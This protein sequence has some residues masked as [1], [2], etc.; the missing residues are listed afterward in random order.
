MTLKLLEILRLSLVVGLVLALIE[1]AA[2][3]GPPELQ[4]PAPVIYLADNL[5]ET[6]N[7]GW[8]IDTVGRGL[9]DRLHAHSCKAF[10]G[11]VQFKYSKASRQIMSATFPGK[12]AQLNSFPA[13]GVRLGLVDCSVADQQKFYFDAGAGE[14]RP[15]ADK[16]LCL[17]VGA[18]S[19]SAGPFMARNLQL[20]PCSSTDPKLKQWI[21]KGGGG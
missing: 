20:A 21:I 13:S 15:T 9:S 12:C 18:N 10:G 3:A 2:E 17:A 6:K 1:T 19:R 7:L 8:C 14:F 4:T 16:S 5:D 11:D